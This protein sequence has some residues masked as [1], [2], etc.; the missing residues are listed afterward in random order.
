V[1]APR[2]LCRAYDGV[3]SA[4]Q[5]QRFLEKFRHQLGYIERSCDA[6]DFGGED[7]AFRLA[8]SLRVIF[9]QTGSSTSLLRHLGWENKQMLSPPRTNG[10]WRDYVR[11]LVN[12][13][14]SEP[15]KVLPLM[16]RGFNPTPIRQWWDGEAIFTHK[17]VG[18]SRRR[19]ILSA[20]NKDGGAH[21]DEDLE[22]YYKV[23]CS[24][25]MIFGITGN[26]QFDG[27]APFPQ[28]VPI[29]VKNAHLAFIRQF[30]HEFRASVRHFRW[31]GN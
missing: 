25:E 29:Y 18:Y 8:V 26:L 22:E 15:V 21:V 13:K 11:L 30:A 10:D 28:G 20:A 27:L 16:G 3:M 12:L 6:F 24:G 4:V 31:L 14:S 23:L 1:C 19:I 2:R 7:E 9:H 5:N 17:Q